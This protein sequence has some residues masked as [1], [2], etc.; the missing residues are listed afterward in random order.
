MN[1]IPRTRDAAHLALAGMV[2]HLDELVDRAF[3][4]NRESG[5]Q[6]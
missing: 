6:I 5:P 1:A 3:N 2:R 4:P